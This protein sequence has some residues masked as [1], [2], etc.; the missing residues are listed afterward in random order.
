MRVYP[1][2]DD[3]RYAISRGKQDH[4]SIMRDVVRSEMEAAR[5][6]MMSEGYDAR[7]VD[8]LGC[9]LQVG[10]GILCSYIAGHIESSGGRTTVTN[11]G[12]VRHV[13]A[14]VIR[15]FMAGRDA[16]TENVTEQ[17]TDPTTNDVRVDPEWEGKLY[18]VLRRCRERAGDPTCVDELRVLIASGVRV[19]ARSK[20][21]PMPPVTG[22]L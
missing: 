11:R 10:E 15:E 13:I 8:G 6:A 22:M 3:Y 12:E 5:S 9:N 7:V 18:A 17:R 14:S 21:A 1:N 19:V 20:Q 4:A 16:V 2:H